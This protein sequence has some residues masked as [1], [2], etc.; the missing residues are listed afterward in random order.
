MPLGLPPLP[1]VAQ[2]LGGS[3]AAGLLVGLQRGWKDRSLPEGGRVAGLRTFTLIGLLG[4]VL[5]WGWGE[6]A[7]PLAAA[8]LVLGGLFAVSWQR[9]ARSAGSLSITTAV[10][11]LVT[12]ALGA[13]AG[14]GQ[15]VAAVAC[16]VLVAV[17]L[18]RKQALHGGLRRLQPNELTA[19]L[20]LAVL[21][22]V[23]LPLLPDAGWG[24]YGALNP[25]RLWLAVVFIAALS[26]A[27]HAA[28]RWR[29]P[30][31][32]LLWVGLLGGLASSTAA[33]LALAR[34]VR[35]QPA[36]AGPA[37]ASVV[38]ASAVMCLR[39]A[40]VVALLQPALAP[41]LGGLLLVLAAA[42][43]LA[44]AGL[45][46]LRGPAMPP[47]AVDAEAKLFDLGT[48]LGFSAVLAVV[49][50]LA[51]AAREAAGDGG[52]LA[53]AFASGLVDVDAIVIATV[54][55]HGQ[56]QLPAATTTA[57][58]LLAAAANLG[59]KAALA[60]GLGGA[61]LGRRVAAGFAVLV[62]GG[63]LAAGVLA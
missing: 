36:L 2:A 60:A 45:W 49:A 24:P 6:A 22:A 18:Q 38:A 21:T 19:L 32:G 41:R 26:L 52:L 42:G 51:R 48:A 50:V 37:A 3:L 23:V 46:R 61:R 57:A 25:F 14:R 27:G 47:A 62:A 17:L 53:V 63:V 34:A 54:Q 13:L 12:L 56:G 8:L 59:V 10:A 7:W 31:Q 16:A 28:S 44:A 30:Q 55:M 29:G 1:E 20:Q 33:T 5:G 11:A 39:M 40:V 58:I 43:A 4:G 35:A 15:P 9:A